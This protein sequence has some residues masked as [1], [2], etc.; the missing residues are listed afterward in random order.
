RFLPATPRRPAPDAFSTSL[1]RFA[2]AIDAAPPPSLRAAWLSHWPLSGPLMPRIVDREGTSMSLSKAIA[3]TATLLLAT[4]ACAD[5][6]ADFYKGKR[7][8]MMVG[9]DA[10]GGYDAYAR[11]VTRHLGKF[12]PGN[13]DFIVQNMPGGGGLRVTNNLYNVQPKD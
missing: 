6:V 5:P 12:I 13:P 7:I 1:E 3:F 4:Q 9:S 11:L 8:N 10:G 2:A